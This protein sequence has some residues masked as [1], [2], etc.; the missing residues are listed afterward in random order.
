MRVGDELAFAHP[1]L[2]EELRLVNIELRAGKARTE[3]LRNLSGPH[4]P[5]RPALARDDADSDR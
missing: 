1:G 3:A 5:G 2:S 4:R